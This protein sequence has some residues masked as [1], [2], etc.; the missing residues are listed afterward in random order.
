M[1]NFKWLLIVFVVLNLAL[2]APS[3]GATTASGPPPGREAAM[4]DSA[5]RG[6]R[7]A[8]SVRDRHSKKREGRASKIRAISLKFSITWRVSK[9]TLA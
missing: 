4:P 8:A 5:G 1:C 3:F 7:G 2:S 6:R 9:R